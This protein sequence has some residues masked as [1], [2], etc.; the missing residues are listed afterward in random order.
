MHAAARST[1]IALRQYERGVISYQP[2]LE[3]QRALVQQQDAL[4][5]SKANID[6]QLVVLYKALGGGWQARLNPAP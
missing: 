6:L 3:S 1:E 4:A 2:L 5:E